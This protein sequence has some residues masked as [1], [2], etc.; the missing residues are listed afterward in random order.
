MSQNF[1]DSVMNWLN[2]GKSPKIETVIGLEDAT[3]TKTAIY[4]TA[5]TAFLLGG[6]K[7]I[8]DSSLKK[9][10]RHMGANI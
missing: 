9:H 4:L 5:I 8:L 10:A 7:L 2:G 3:L 1:L 6:L